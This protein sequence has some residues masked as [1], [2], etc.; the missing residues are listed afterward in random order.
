MQLR[1]VA[2]LGI[3]GLKKFMFVLAVGPMQPLRPQAG[4]D[5]EGWG[6]TSSCTHYVLP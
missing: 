4:A 1:L 5:L 6:V 2:F 3:M